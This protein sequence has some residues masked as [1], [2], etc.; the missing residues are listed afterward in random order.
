MINDERLKTV[1]DSGNAMQC[2]VS[3][4]ATDFLR[5]KL[6]IDLLRAELL[7]AREGHERLLKQLDLSHVRGGKLEEA[8]AELREIKAALTEDGRCTR[9]AQW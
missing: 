1:A 8:E 5:Q 4:L 2:E 6:Q 9:I 3:E 7:S